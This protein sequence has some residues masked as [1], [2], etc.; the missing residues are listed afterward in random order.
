[1]PGVPGEQRSTPMGCAV[2]R[3]DGWTW[4]CRY[5]LRVFTLGLGPD[6]TDFDSQAWLDA[7][8]SNHRC[9]RAPNCGEPD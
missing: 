8:D 3:A 5:C 4:T 2:R 1:V 7:I 9:E 6:V